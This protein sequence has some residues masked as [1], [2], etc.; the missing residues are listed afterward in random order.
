MS[1]IITD[2]G[3]RRAHGA[4]EQ[5]LQMAVEIAAVV[6]PGQAVGHR[7]FDGLG[8]AGAQLVVVAL[9]AHLGAQPRR[10]LLLVDRPHQIVV[11]AEF[12]AADDAR[13]L[14]LLRQQDDRQE[15]GA[16]ERAQLRAKPQRIEIGEGR[17]DHHAFIGRLG[18]LEEA[19]MRIAG[20]VEL[21]AV[22]QHLLDALDG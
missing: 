7:H 17:R 5:R 21:R 11:D 1:V 22:A 2:S 20:D 13:L 15:A 12:E 18:R 19:G 8:D 14:A 4:V 10:Q 3:R 6:Q 16:V 9:A